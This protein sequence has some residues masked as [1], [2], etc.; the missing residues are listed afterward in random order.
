MKAAWWWID[1]WRKSTAYTDMTC[2]E[3]GAYRELLD[4][5][6][7]RNG[8]IP[9]DDRI[10]ARIVGDAEAWK[11]VREVVLRRFRLT[12]EGYR[13]DTHDEVS[14]YPKRQSEK[15]RSRAAN[16][17]RN[18][19]RFTSRPPAEHQPS[20]QPNTSQ[21]LASGWASTPPAEHQPPSPSPSLTEERIDRLQADHRPAPKNPL[22][23]RRAY[24]SEALSLT[25]EIAALKDCDP[26][27]V[28]AEAARYEG[29]QRS[30]VNPASM[31]D[32]RLANT[33]LDLRA[34]LAAAK[35]KR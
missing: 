30:K 3:R 5:L 28:F 12:P 24:E 2:E 7:L 11:R 14:T 20:H 32:D 16:G 22:I 8:V 35:A 25:R 23:D 4:E 9:A 33:V 34:T 26:V 29:A 10:L 15:G 31:T 1:R 21:R 18:G 13:N 17:S 27:E 19:G 6:W